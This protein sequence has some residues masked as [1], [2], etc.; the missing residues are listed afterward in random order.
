MK[1][2]HRKKRSCCFLLFKYIT[3]I[4]LLA[5]LIGAGFTVPFNIETLKNY[6]AESINRSTS[7][8]IPTISLPTYIANSTQIATFGKYFVYGF[9]GFLASLVGVG[10]IAA[11]CESYCLMVFVSVLMVLTTLV[12]SVACVFSVLLYNRPPYFNLIELIVNLVATLFTLAFAGILKHT[13]NGRSSTPVVPI[14]ENGITQLKPSVPKPPTPYP[15]K[16]M[17]KKD[18]SDTES[19][20]ENQPEELEKDDLTEVKVIENQ[21]SEENPETVVVLDEELNDS[22]ADGSKSPEQE[23]EVIASA[24]QEEKPE[25]K[26]TDDSET[27]ELNPKPDEQEG[28]E[29]RSPKIDTI[30]EEDEPDGQGDQKK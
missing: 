25:D 12:T 11:S 14:N 8:L 26:P 28:T 18:E 3:I 2:G 17:L 1:D 10:L 30:E 21:E 7:S 20:D 29:A 23:A 27:E 4:A 15:P 19:S 6:Q 9:V 22:T 24:E 13:S 16:V 5:S